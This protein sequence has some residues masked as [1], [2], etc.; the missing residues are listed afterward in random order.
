MCTILNRA[1]CLPNDDL[2]TAYWS[3]LNSRRVLNHSFKIEII[4]DKKR[5]FHCKQIKNWTWK[6]YQCG[7]IINQK[8]IFGKIQ[9]W[10]FIWKPMAFHRLTYLFFS[11]SLGVLKLQKY[12]I[13]GSYLHFSL[14]LHISMSQF[15]FARILRVP[16][17]QFHCV[18]S[19]CS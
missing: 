12:T 18:C 3:K 4:T 10:L 9:T 7:L 11:L 15:G 6:R 13:F 5:I 16:F 2:L 17:C 1:K 8:S 14:G 19:F